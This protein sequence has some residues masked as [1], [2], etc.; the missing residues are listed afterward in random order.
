[1]RR[2][3]TVAAV[4]LS[5]DASSV[6]EITSGIAYLE[7][8]LLR[9]L[10]VRLL[11]L[12]H[13]KAFLVACFRGTH[14]ACILFLELLLRRFV[15]GNAYKAVELFV[16]LRKID[17]SAAARIDDADASRALRLDG[18]L[19]LFLARSLHTLV[20]YI[21]RHGARRG[22]AADSV[23]E[24]ER[25]APAD[26]PPLQPSHPLCGCARQPSPFPPP[27]LS[28]VRRRNVCVPRRDCG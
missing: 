13:R 19:L 25:P 22:D 8:C 7:R 15:I 27:P 21:H 4:T 11:Y 16:V 20:L 14:I 26:A 5:L 2:F 23:S 6:T 17:I 3:T 12:L 1:M 9:L 24:P 18:R 10:G 28:C